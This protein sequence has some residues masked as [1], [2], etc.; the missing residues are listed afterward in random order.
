MD[1]FA[2]KCLYRMRSDP[3]R[4]NKIRLD[5]T[6]SG[7]HRNVRQPRAARME[8][9]GCFAGNPSL[10]ISAQTLLIVTRCERARWIAGPVL[11]SDSRNFEKPYKLWKLW[12][13]IDSPDTK[14][15][16]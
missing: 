6:W 2:R 12:L 3:Q 11:P 1:R 9:D 15:R 14:L 4:F 7:H 8:V 10:L 5:H 16:H 13:A